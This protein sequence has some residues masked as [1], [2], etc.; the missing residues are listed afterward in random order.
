MYSKVIFPS[1]SS[2]P[3]TMNWINQIRSNSFSYSWNTIRP[4]MIFI[5]LLIKCLL[6]NWHFSCPP[7]KEVEKTVKKNKSKFSF[8]TS[9]TYTLIEGIINIGSLNSWHKQKIRYR[10]FSNLDIIFIPYPLH[11]IWSSLS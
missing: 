8:L 4:T 9:G 10:L 3:A 11:L 7:C 1:E 6:N 2:S 5:Y